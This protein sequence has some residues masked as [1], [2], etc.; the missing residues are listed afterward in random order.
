M[1][2]ESGGGGEK[3]ALQLHRSLVNFLMWLSSLAQIEELAGKLTRKLHN[4]CELDVLSNKCMACMGKKKKESSMKA[5]M[6]SAA[7][8]IHNM[9]I[10]IWL[11]NLRPDCFPQEIK[12]LTIIIL[13]N[14]YQ[15]GKLPKITD[16][17]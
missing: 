12:V 4:E 3:G 7:E 14:F 13:L 17:H 11:N 2:C 15:N 8:Q 1:R 6:N 10:I 5:A 16:K 9:Q